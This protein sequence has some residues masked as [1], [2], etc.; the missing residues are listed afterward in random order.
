MNPKDYAKSLRLVA[1]FYDKVEDD[2]PVPDG[3]LTKSFYYTPNSNKDMARRIAK[4]LGNCEKSY[5]GSL[6]E[7]FKDFEGLCLGFIFG[8]DTVCEKKVVGTKEVPSCY[9]PSHMEEIIEWDCKSILSQEEA[10]ALHQA[11]GPIEIKEAS[12]EDT[13]RNEGGIDFPF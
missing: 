10:D 5:S 11:A 12:G 2:F 3:A 8:R 1:D 6:F 13:N 4:G 7:I 9:I